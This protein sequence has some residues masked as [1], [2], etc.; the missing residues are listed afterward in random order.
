MLIVAF[1]NRFRYL[2]GCFGLAV[3]VEQAL[4]IVE[5]VLY[6]HIAEIL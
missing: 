2:Q 3:T 6:C 4:A 1:I 5:R